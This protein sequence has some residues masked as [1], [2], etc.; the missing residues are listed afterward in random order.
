MIGNCPK[1]QARM[2][3]LLDSSNMS[4]IERI[5]CTPEVR[6]TMK[7]YICCKTRDIKCAYKGQPGVC[8]PRENCPLKKTLTVGQRNAWSNQK[9]CYV[10]D[11]TEYLCCTNPHCVS[12]HKLCDKQKPAAQQTT[13]GFPKCLAKG[14]PGLIVPKAM[15]S[16]QDLLQ[17]VKNSKHVCCATPTT[18]R[19]ISH[20]NAAKLANMLCGTVEHMV[21]VQGGE[22]A[23]R[24]EFPW[25]A[26]LAYSYKHTRCGGSLIHP[27]YVLT[28]KHCVKPPAKPTRVLLGVHDV[29]DTPPCRKTFRQSFCAQV[30]QITISETLH[31]HY[32][33]IALVRLAAK[34]ILSQDRVYPICLP[35]YV[36]L[37]RQMPESVIIT[38]WGKT[39]NEMLS[40]VLLKATTKVV[41]RG[42]ECPNDHVICSGGVNNSNHC[43][44]DS[45]GPYQAIRKFGGSMRYVQYGV[46]SSGSMYCS[47]S[48]R[49]SQGMLVSYFMDWILDNMAL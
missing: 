17:R 46:I 48:E 21:K 13:F 5:S 40:N 22:I 10:H 43:A 25:M 47:I 12:N 27:F 20:P 14:I 38:G 30:Q 16:A 8:V 11:G 33:D 37:L 1:K 23:Q 26:Y 41:M 44:G 7:K 31:H 35:L 3:E 42:K 39:E 19:L 29:Q 2:K 24:G 49:R 6:L 28:A 9:P 15:C 36:S 32:Y 18:D 45:G 4:E 34:A